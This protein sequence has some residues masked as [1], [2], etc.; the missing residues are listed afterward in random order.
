MKEFSWGAVMRYC[1]F[2]LKIPPK[3]FWEM[4]MVEVLFLSETDESHQ[5]ISRKDL[6]YMMRNF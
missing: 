5:Q 4:T 6:E 2:I 3:D 1:Y